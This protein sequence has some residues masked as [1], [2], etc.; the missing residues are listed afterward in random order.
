MLE[1][2][3]IKTDKGIFLTDNPRSYKSSRLLDLKVNG[4][5]PEETYSKGWYYVDI[6][7]VEKIEKKGSREKINVRYELNDPELES[8]KLPLV[9]LEE[10]F[11]NE[12]SYASLYNYE[13]DLAEQKWGEIEYEINTLFE[14]EDYYFRP[15]AK[16]TG[17]S[18]VSFSTKDVE[19]NN[20]NFKHQGLDKML[21]PELMLHN[22]PCKIASKDLYNILRKFI[23]ENIDH[24][25]AKITSDY[26]FCFT[27]KKRRYDKDAFD[28]VTELES[29][30]LRDRRISS[31]TETT[32]FEM[33]SEEENHKRYPILPSIKANSEKELI[34]KID[35]YLERVI[36][37]INEPL[38]ECSH[39][40]GRGY[41]NVQEKFDLR[42]GK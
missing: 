24:R 35:N 3:M 12:A 14:V 42:E 10:D 32:V 19:I 4:V 16:Y 2:D 28:L 8:E 23:K 41:V 21:I 11:D 13:Y 34:E 33:T 40:D 18:K 9:M 36:T 7:E 27:V 17:E 6:D 38:V 29:N 5:K 1:L 39:C 31:N 30:I 37:H 25:Y 20:A 26:N 22:Y 15:K